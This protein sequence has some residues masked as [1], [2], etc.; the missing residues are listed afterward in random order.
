VKRIT[1]PYA[2]NIKLSTPIK[3]VRRSGNAV[4]LVDG[5]GVSYA[6]DDVVIATHADQALYAAKAG[7][8]NMVMAYTEQQSFSHLV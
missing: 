4:E 3:T 2:D 6:F 8:R 7:G 5:N 1:K